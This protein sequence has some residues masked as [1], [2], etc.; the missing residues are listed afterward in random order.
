MSH[1]ASV[2]PS[3]R[4]LP[5][6]KGSCRSS[7]QSP[8]FFARSPCLRGPALLHN[9]ALTRRER[10]RGTYS[11]F[12]YSISA[13]ISQTL[14]EWTSCLALIGYIE[15]QQPLF[16]QVFT[17]C[18]VQHRTHTAGGGWRHRLGGVY[19]FDH[20]TYVCMYCAAERKPLEWANLTLWGLAYR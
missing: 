5:G 18:M 11:T 2:R 13:G 19:A 10:K 17:D 1:D 8:L 3:I 6:P 12:L 15:V 14:I 7:V 9:Y 20:F 16:K 4:Y